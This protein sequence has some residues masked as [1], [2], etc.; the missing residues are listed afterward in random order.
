M[1]EVRILSPER[2]YKCYY[3]S[4]FQRNQVELALKACVHTDLLLRAASPP[5]QKLGQKR[6]VGPFGASLARSLTAFARGT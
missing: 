1:L 2:S 6:G 3:N 4:L 5:W